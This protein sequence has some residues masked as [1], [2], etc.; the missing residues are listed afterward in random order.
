MSYKDYYNHTERS[1]DYLLLV[2]SVNVTLFHS[3]KC[4]QHYC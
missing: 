1:K 3:S 4:R 2:L